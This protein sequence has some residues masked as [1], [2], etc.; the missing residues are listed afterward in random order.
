MDDYIKE[1]A[2]MRFALQ[3]YAA[4]DGIKVLF[5]YVIFGLTCFC[6]GFSASEQG[7]FH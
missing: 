3:L 5:W 6:L 7:W 1:L 2:A 4:M